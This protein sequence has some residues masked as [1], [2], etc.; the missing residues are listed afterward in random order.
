[1]AIAALLPSQ[2][3]TVRVS[4][5]GSRGGSRGEDS[6][7][8]FSPRSAVSQ[9]SGSVDLQVNLEYLQGCQRTHT[10]QLSVP[11]APPFRCVVLV[12]FCL[13]LA[14]SPHRLYV[15][16]RLGCDFEKTASFTCSSQLLSLSFTHCSVVWILH[17][18]ACCPS[19]AAADTIILV[20][21]MTK[22]K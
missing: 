3:E 5:L 8:L 20:C 21:R 12:L 17:C 14:T 15:A 2:H 7:L 1:M 13:H 9:R 10:A 18:L 4:P 19:I 6:G 16:Q 22:Y 11:I